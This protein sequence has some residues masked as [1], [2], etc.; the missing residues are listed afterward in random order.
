MSRQRKEVHEALQVIAGPLV[1][2]NV[3]LSWWTTSNKHNFKAQS[4]NWKAWFSCQKMTFYWFQ[5][6]TTKLVNILR[7]ATFSLLSSTA[8][9]KF[10]PRKSVLSMCWSECNDKISKTREMWLTDFLPCHDPTRVSILHLFFVVQFF[11]DQ[12]FLF[13]FSSGHNL[14]YFL[15]VGCHLHYICVVAQKTEDKKE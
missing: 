9:I 5:L 4:S 1:D 15:H 13:L 10:K 14:L 6:S 11:H 7:L 12:Y 8:V 3:V 2:M